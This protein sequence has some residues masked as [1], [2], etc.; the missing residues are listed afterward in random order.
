MGKGKFIAYGGE[1]DK[2]GKS[3]KINRDNMHIVIYDMGRFFGIRI[4]YYIPLDNTYVLFQMLVTF[5]IL[6]TIGAVFLFKYKPSIVDPIADMKRTIINI[7]VIVNVVLLAFILIANPLSKNKNTLIK[8]L[9]VLL[10]IS[11]ITFLIFGGIKINLN[12]MYNKNKFEQIYLQEYGESISNAKAKVDLSLSTGMKIKTE[13][14]YYVDECLKAYNVFSIRMYILTGMNLLLI[15]LLI[16]QIHK[17]SKIKEKLDKLSKDDAVLF[18]E[19]EN[20]KI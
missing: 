19:E 10:I 16:Y 2:D 13:K 17:V 8:R 9:F 4:H 14:E 12:T 18:D 6:I 20:V 3:S 1:F 5:I 11:I 15:T 7:Y